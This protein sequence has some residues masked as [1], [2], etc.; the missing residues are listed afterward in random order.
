MEDNDF[1]HDKPAY[2]SYSSDHIV[3]FI[4]LILSA[5]TSLRSTSRVIETVVSFFH[6]PVNC[7]SWFTGRLWLLRLGLYK[8][9][10][11]KEVANDWVWIVDHTI[12]ISPEKCLVVLGLR[13]SELRICTRSLTH[14]DVEPIALFPVKKS[15]GD[16][17]YE[18]LKEAEEKTGIPREIIA[19]QGSDLTAGIKKYC[20]ERSETCSIYDIKHK[21]AGLLKKELQDDRDWQEFVKLSGETKRALQQ[22]DLAHLCPPNQRSKSRYMNVDILVK[23]GRKTLTWY[24][25][26]RGESSDEAQKVHEEL[27]WISEFRQELDKWESLMNI[28]LRAESF[29]RREGL[30]NGCHHKLKAE[31]NKEIVSERSKEFSKKYFDFVKRECSK[32]GPGECLLGSSEV[33]E[34]VFGKLKRVE[35]QQSKSGFTGLLLSIGAMVSQTTRE[36]VQKAME[37]VSTKDL[38]DWC[39]KNLGKSVQAKRKEAF[40]LATETE[41]K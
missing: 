7:P 40:K 15:N 4:T 23:W 9:T 14:E 38:L 22:T 17:V 31:L 39:K 33:I 26:Y 13:L 21:S 12:Q 8:L 16:I 18:Q 25:S 34:S 11:P 41:Q 19:D 24:D 5:A 1:F 10:R 2:H 28:A 27:G 35:G 36:I 3:L 30:Y 37:S 6:L 29:V 32:A 20:G